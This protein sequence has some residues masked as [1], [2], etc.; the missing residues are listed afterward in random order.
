MLSA[1]LLVVQ[2]KAKDVTKH[3]TLKVVDKDF[4]VYRYNYIRSKDT[5]YKNIDS[6]YDSV[7]EP[8]SKEY[9]LDMAGQVIDY[10]N[11]DNQLAYAPVNYGYMK[12]IQFKSWDTYKDRLLGKAPEMFYKPYK[13]SIRLD[14]DY[15]KD[16]DLIK[17]SLMKQYNL[18]SNEINIKFDYR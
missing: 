12:S 8:T 5:Y 13:I 17:L 4:E 6:I 1:L 16:K 3:P 14:R 11:S 9:T 18:K 15:F 2:L 10:V 7:D